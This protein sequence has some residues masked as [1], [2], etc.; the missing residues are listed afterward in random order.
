M[1]VNFVS[2]AYLIVMTALWISCFILNITVD[3]SEISVMSRIENMDIIMVIVS[4]I[5]WLACGAAY[6]TEWRKKKAAHRLYILL[7]LAV[8]FILYLRFI[9]YEN[10]ADDYSFVYLFVV[11]AGWFFLSGI[12]ENK[13]IFIILG[14]IALICMILFFLYLVYSQIVFFFI[15]LLPLLAAVIHELYLNYLERMQDESLV[16][17][18]K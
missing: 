1:K 10:H 9:S 7:N 5:L 16:L 14:Y 6:L 13:R 12:R 2:K 3:L 17:E 18:E 4:S 11:Y 8:F 15:P